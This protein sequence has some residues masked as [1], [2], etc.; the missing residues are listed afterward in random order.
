[1]GFAA[2]SM[3]AI[4]FIALPYRAAFIKARTELDQLRRCGRF[5][6]PKELESIEE[7]RRMHKEE[8]SND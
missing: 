2:G 5:L 8:G 1:M 4:F 7:G 3:F 6:T